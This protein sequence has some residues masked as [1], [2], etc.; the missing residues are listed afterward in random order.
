MG[1]A[2]ETPDRLRPAETLPADL[3]ATDLAVTVVRAHDAVWVDVS[4]AFCE[5]VGHSRDELIGRTPVALGMSDPKR[6]AWLIERF[7]ARGA[8]YAHVR[9]FDTPHGPRLTR[10][11]LH[12]VEIG[13]ERYVIAVMHEL[14]EDA[15]PGEAD[16]LGAMMDGAPV[17]VVV[18]DRDLRIMRVNRAVEEMGRIGPQHI[19]MRVTDVFEAVD[20]RLIAGIGEVVDLRRPVVNLYLS[21]SD[22]R[23]YLVNLF[24]IRRPDGEV[25]Q[26]GCI[27]S[28]VTERMAAERALVESEAHRRQILLTLLQAEEAER[29]RIATELHD[30]TVQVMTAVLLSMD[31]VAIAARKTGQDAIEQAVTLARSTLEEATDRARRLM[32]ELRPA[33]L[34]ERGLLPALGMLADQTARETGAVAEVRAHVGRHEREIEELVYRT[35]QEALANI[36]KHAAPTRITVTVKDAGGRLS[37]EVVDDGQGFDV[38]RAKARPRAA[39]HLGLDSLEERLRAVGGEIEVDSAPGAGTRLRFTVPFADRAGP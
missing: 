37:G 4:D 3:E 32:F 31:R 34:Y 29:S 2:H 33:I 12:G 22:E 36:R 18:Y 1:G 20:P 5:L 30:D 14:S 7:P 10:M 23:S 35:V 24:P 17:G 13:G 39:L 27:F 16:I 15:L 11:H 8:G 19:G 21:S 6:L 28:D 26:V 38:A 9:V 25:V